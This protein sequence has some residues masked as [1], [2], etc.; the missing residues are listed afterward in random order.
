MHL[1]VPAYRGAPLF[2]VG[3]VVFLHQQPIS[4]A[5]G[6]CL[7]QWVVFMHTSDIRTPEYNEHGLIRPMRGQGKLGD[8]AANYVL[9]YED[10]T[11]HSIPVR[12]RYEIGMFTRMWREN[13]FTAV[14]H[15]ID[16]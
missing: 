3:P 5:I 15:R 8:H 1:M 4:V 12:R 2:L 16:S 9:V 14:A 11:E 6:E 7:D 10:G 13:S